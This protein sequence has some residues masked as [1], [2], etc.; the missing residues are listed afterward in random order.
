MLVSFLHLFSSSDCCM[1]HASSSHFLGIRSLI[2]C[3]V[4]SWGIA[5]KDLVQIQNAQMLKF[6][7]ENGVM[8]AYALHNPPMYFYI[9]SKHFYWCILIVCSDRLYKHNFFQVYH[10][11]QPSLP[12]LPFSFSSLFPTSLLPASPLS[13]IETNIER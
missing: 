2:C 11:C 4:A 6:P 10:E 12:L 9:F 1:L 3:A 13:Y 8:L 5:S 7:I